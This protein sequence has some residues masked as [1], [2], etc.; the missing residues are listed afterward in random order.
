LEQEEEEDWNDGENPV[1]L[2]EAV[3]LA[4]FEMRHQLRDATH[5]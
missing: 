1:D 2:L 4:S 3:I 5:A